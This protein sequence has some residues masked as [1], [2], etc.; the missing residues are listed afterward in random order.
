MQ[1]KLN[2]RALLEQVFPGYKQVFSNVFSAT[3]LRVLSHC[4]EGD[5]ADWIE[6]IQ[7]STGRSR[8]K[9]NEK[10]RKLEEVLI[11]WNET[12][13]SPT[14]NQAFQGM[15]TLLLTMIQQLD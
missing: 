12:W 11:D 2:S 10:A 4:L 14:Q 9:A 6:V 15:V 8:S 7:K 5:T 13:R 3:S 1:A